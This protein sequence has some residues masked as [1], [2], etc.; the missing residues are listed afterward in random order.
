MLP[1]AKHPS[2]SLPPARMG[3]WLRAPSAGVRHLACGRVE[4][5]ANRIPLA[6]DCVLRH[7]G[8]GTV[9]IPLKRLL[10]ERELKPL[11]PRGSVPARRE[12]TSLKMGSRLISCGRNF[13]RL[14]GRKQARPS[15]SSHIHKGLLRKLH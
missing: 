10:H 9:A 8:T 11:R 12:R 6:C 13:L 5:T 1:Q 4:C 2:S 7:C 14:G 15:V 3:S